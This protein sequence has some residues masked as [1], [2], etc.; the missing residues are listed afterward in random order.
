MAA[1]TERRRLAMKVALGI[2]PT[3]TKTPLNA[4]VHG[5]Q[6]HGNYT[7]EKVYFESLPG[8]YVTGN[9]YRPKGFEGQHP[10]VI[11]PHGHFQD[12]RFGDQGRDHVRREIMVGAERFEVG[13]RNPIQARCVQLARMGCVVFNYDMI[14]YCDSV[15]LSFDLAHRF[16]RQRPELNRPEEW[17]LFSPQA[18]SMLQSV[19]GLQAWNSI[20]A[21]D[22]ISQLP[23]VDPDRIAVTGASGGGTQTFILGA[24]DPRPAVL[25]P[26]VMVS[27]AMQG[28]CT[29]ENASLLRIN[30]GNIEFAA[31]IA[32]RP[33]CLTAA[34]DWTREMPTKGFPELKEQYERLGAG[35]QIEL[36][37]L[38]HFGH[39]YNYVSREV[40]YQFL[41]HHLQLGLAEPVIE[42]DY[43][44]LTRSELSV[45]DDDH[46]QPET[47]LETEIRLLKTWA[48][49]TKQQLLKARPHDIA[50]LQEYRDVVAPALDVVLGRRLTDVGA[51]EFDQRDKSQWDGGWLITGLLRHRPLDQDPGRPEQHEVL[52][53]AFLVPEGWDAGPVAIWL[54]P[55]GKDGLFEGGQ[56]REEVRRLV[57]GGVAVIGVDLMEQGEL[58]TGVRPLTETRRVENTRE[59]AAYTCGYNTS[60]FAQRV[61]DVLTVIRFATDHPRT[62]SQ[63]WLVG[64]E[65]AG[66]WAAAARAQATAHST[67]PPSI[68]EDSGLSTSRVFATRSSFRE[69][70][71]MMIYPAC[72]PWRHLMPCGWPEKRKRQVSWFVM[73]MRPPA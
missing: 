67:A 69:G 55:D 56:P 54:D 12:G 44:R 16:A 31:L 40:M 62:P 11:S 43:P 41:N 29:C 28:G 22:W 4:V 25:V 45:W 36:H 34:N 64:L 1:A 2:W 10:A 59:A 38:L 72:L 14:G 70:Q 6:D 8:F 30:T 7:I 65:G 52:P 51:V 23:N 53:I 50:T 39:N 9:L 15:Q 26:A 48:A 46:P 21:L 5:L 58:M 24:I 73:R 63:I 57:A 61:Q 13:G 68:A 33:L 42:E 71:N 20:R 37:P 19:M 60:L 66:P 18:E 3:P 35:D 27:T 49:D 17:G 47:G 32:P